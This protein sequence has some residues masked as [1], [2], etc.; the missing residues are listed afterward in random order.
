MNQI[1]TST[2]HIFGLCE[3][4]LNLTYTYSN[5]YIPLPCQID[6]QYIVTKVCTNIP[7]AI[8]FKCSR[9]TI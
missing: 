8:V 5:G 1:I 6:E 2:I 7:L 3:S 4:G 9:V